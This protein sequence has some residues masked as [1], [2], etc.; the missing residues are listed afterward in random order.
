MNSAA[1]CAHFGN[2][3]DGTVAPLRNSI[4]MYNAWVASIASCMVVLTD[5]RIN[6]M[7]RN[8]H[9]P[10]DAISSSEIQCRGKGIPY[11]KWAIPSRVATTGIY[12]SHPLTIAATRIGMGE[13]GVTLKRRR[14]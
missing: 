12:S 3:A 13:I 2:T 10:S 7:D 4:G 1:V 8:A 11:L 5:A 9:T 14:M 6:P